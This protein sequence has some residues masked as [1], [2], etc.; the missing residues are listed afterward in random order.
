MKTHF[1]WFDKKCSIRIVHNGGDRNQTSRKA[2]KQKDLIPLIK[3]L[4]CCFMIILRSISLKMYFKI[5][6]IC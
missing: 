1:K 4:R 3:N 6:A 2:N 5:Y